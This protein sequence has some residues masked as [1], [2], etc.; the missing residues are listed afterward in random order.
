MTPPRRSFLVLFLLVGSSGF[1][2]A[3]QAAAPL[4]WKAGVAR[5]D[6]TPD[7]PVWMGGYA[8]RKKPSEGVAQRVHAKALAL[9]GAGGRPLVIVTLDLVSIPRY[10][11]A[12]IAQRV[13]AVHG[14]PPDALLFNA[15]HTHAGPEDRKSVV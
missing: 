7:D 10:L 1:G 13:Q 11:R 6:L 12:D 4:E 3:P 2:A 5:V 8:S 9:E 15:S 14:L